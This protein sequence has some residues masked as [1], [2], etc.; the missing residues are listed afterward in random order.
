LRTSAEPEYNT[1][2]LLVCQASL[3]SQY[4]RHLSPYIK[5]DWFISENVISQLQTDISIVTEMG[6]ETFTST[7]TFLTLNTSHNGNYTCQTFLR[8]PHRNLTIG[9][10]NSLPLFLEG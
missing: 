3:P 4:I 10:S 6:P 7:L 8:L 2:F 9:Q 1:Q 5:F